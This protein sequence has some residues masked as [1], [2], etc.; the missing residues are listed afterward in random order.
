MGGRRY[1]AV[2]NQRRSRISSWKE[3]MRNRYRLAL[4]AAPLTALLGVFA[5][6]A[7][8]AGAATAAVPTGPTSAVAY[9]IGIGHDGYSAD[10]SIK[11]PLSEKW[12][13]SFS[14]G[15]SYPLIVGGKVFVTVASSSGYGTTLYALN[16]NTGATI[17]SQAISGT[18]Y[19]SNAAYDA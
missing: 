7:S 9:Q 5:A 11:P 19:W 4:A 2:V 14:G 6:P 13:V 8:P 10:T 16:K 17:W 12:S 3:S 18:Y 1:H 15:V